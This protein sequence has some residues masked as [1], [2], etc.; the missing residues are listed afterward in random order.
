MKKI[1]QSV[2]DRVSLIAAE[3]SGDECW[4]W[5]KYRNPQTGYGQ[6]SCKRGLPKAKLFTAHRA[7]WTATHGEIPDGMHVL[8]RCDNRGCFN[9]AHLFLGTHADN[10]RDMNRKGRAGQRKNPARGERHGSVTKPGRIPRGEANNKAKL[11][12]EA[13]L[14][15][16]SGNARPTE[17]AKKYGVTYEAI[18]NVVLRKTWRHINP[19]SSQDQTP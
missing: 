7:I 12:A 11:T 1:P 14:E 19:V 3:F 18:R 17:L 10:M 6:L 9:P 5:P 2:I 4:G 15:I 13:V 8:H 16:L